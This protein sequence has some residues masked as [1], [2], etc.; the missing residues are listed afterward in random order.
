MSVT[1]GAYSLPDPVS[2]GAEGETEE[3]S[4]VLEMADGSFR[5]H[6]LSQRKV[7][8]YTWIRDGSTGENIQTAIRA[9]IAA[10]SFTFKPWD[11]VT[12]YTVEVVAGSH[13]WRQRPYRGGTRWTISARFRE[14]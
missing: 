4:E 11:E 14:L 2:T 13:R 8:N 12:T 10:V 7:W 1:V 9:A 3:N 6:L 5:K